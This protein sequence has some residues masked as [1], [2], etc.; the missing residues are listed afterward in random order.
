MS[1]GTHNPI[2]ARP[3]CAKVPGPWGGLGGGR[4]LPQNAA[5]A[6]VLRQKFCGPQPEV[7]GS[8]PRPLSHGALPGVCGQVMGTPCCCA[9]RPR[10][11]KPLGGRTTK[12][13]RVCRPAGVGREGASGGPLGGGGGGDTPLR[14]R[15]GGPSLA[16]WPQLGGAPPTPTGAGGGRADKVWACRDPPGG[17][18][19]GIVLTRTARPWCG[20]RVCKKNEVARRVGLD[21]RRLDGASGSGRGLCGHTS[22]RWT[23]NLPTHSPSCVCAVAPRQR[24]ASTASKQHS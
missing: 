21:A 3:P 2:Q 16:L 10:Q 6:V 19:C 24:H 17:P 1:G 23:P 14:G 18:A 15:S 11:G 5:Q 13:R 12:A 20:G 9:A 7:G 4:G 22:V 8:P